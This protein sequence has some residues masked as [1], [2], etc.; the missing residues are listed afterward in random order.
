MSVSVTVRHASVDDAPDLARV[1][2]ESWLG[3]YRGLL[4]DEVL[5]RLSVARRT[6]QW[7]EW[8]SPDGDRVPTLLAE[9]ERPVGFASL[10]IPSHDAD[11]PEGVGEIPALYVEPA[12]W[13]R[14][15]GRVLIEAAADELR[16]AGCRE[17]ILWM[18]EG[19]ERADAFYRRV[20]WHRDGGRRASQHYPD[21]NY[22]QLDQPLM[23]VRFRRGL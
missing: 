4:P 15:A 11:E 1:H 7:R 6:Q 22:A 2:V 21:V 19:N 13:G 8:L 20:G 9:I 16:E 12:A 10:A 23:E 18:L 17:G 5:D 14:G 3:G